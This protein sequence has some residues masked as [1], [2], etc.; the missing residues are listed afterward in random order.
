MSHG[1]AKKKADAIPL[2][3]KEVGQSDGLSQIEL[4]RLILAELK[5][6]NLAIFMLQES[7]AT[8]VDPE[9]IAS[10]FYKTQLK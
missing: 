2:E 9:D 3:T 8:R 4:L 6:I 7:R 5:A 10:D 1:L